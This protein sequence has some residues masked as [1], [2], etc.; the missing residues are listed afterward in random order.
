M[1][2]CGRQFLRASLIPLCILLLICSHLAVGPLRVN[3]LLA[4]AQS[5]E[6]QELEVF[7]GYLDP[8]PEGMDVRYAW[9]L[10]GGRG[11]NVR[12]ID[13]EFNWN[14]KHNDLAAA[15]ADP[16]IVVKGVDPLP[17]DRLDNVNHGTAVLGELVAAPDGI[18]VTG[19]AHLARIGVINP[20]ASGTTANVADAIR[21]AIRKLSPGDVIL[22]E[23]Q[24]IT[25]PRFDASTG[26]GFLP[27]EFEPA[28]FAA[29][30]DATSEGIIVVE[31]AANGNESLDHSAY[32]GAFNRSNRDS[33]AIIV[34]AGMPPGPGVYGPGPDRSRTRES[35]YGS[36][37]DVQGWGRFVTTCGY[38]EH[39]FEQGANNWYTSQFGATSGAAAM[40]AGAVALIQSIAKERGLEPLSPS[41]MRSL[42]TLTGSPQTGDLSENIGPRPDLRAAIAALESDVTDL[43]PRITAVKL[44]KSNGKLTVDGQ[45][46]LVN[47]SIIEIDG[48]AVSKLKY[49]SENV[50]PGGITTR[51]VSKR[52]VSGM[53]PRGVEVSITIFTTSS[54]RRSEPFIFRYN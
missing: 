42:L 43:A 18:G 21:Q 26:Q 4:S 25:G 11:Q 37:V 41:Q 50:L 53:I 12:I 3:N 34:G 54:G 7:Q 46:F 20:V 14:A 48:V 10:P 8:A 47:D 5:W 33:G 22:V 38:G 44:K 27:I 2:T 13:I 31:P 24:S 9:S 52:D 51:I 16:V 32:K 6:P 23:Q 35:N 45:Q 30:R 15:F 49:P 28:V 1:S 29:I 39:R 17:P 40:V 19:I 36:R